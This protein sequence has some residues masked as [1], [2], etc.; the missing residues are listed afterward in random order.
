MESNEC[1]AVILERRALHSP[2]FSPEDIFLSV[3][4][5]VKPGQRAALLLGVGGRE[6]N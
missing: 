4:G 1:K 3:T 2:R 5:E 6:G